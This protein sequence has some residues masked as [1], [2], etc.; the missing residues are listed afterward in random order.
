MLFLKFNISDITVYLRLP[1]TCNFL[2]FDAPC[3]N[4]FTDLLTS[5]LK[6]FKFLQNV[7]KLLV[8]RAHGADK[9]VH[10]LINKLTKCCQ[11]RIEY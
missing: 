9:L 6:D 11:K 7:V 2:V 10:V 4:S 1:H 5:R 8:A 3:L